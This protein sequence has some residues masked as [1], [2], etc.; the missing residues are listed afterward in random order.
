MPLS[1]LDHLGYRLM[2]IHPFV[3][4]S[5]IPST[6]STYNLVKL[7]GLNFPIMNAYYFTQ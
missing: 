6:R 1:Q 2:A 5:T 7:A 4:H 3:Y